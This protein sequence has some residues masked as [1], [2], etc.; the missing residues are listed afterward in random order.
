MD[1]DLLEAYLRV[2]RSQNVM[3]AQLDLPCGKVS[4]VMGPEALEAAPTL[5]APGA[6]KTAGWATPAG[7]E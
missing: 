4:V 3:S 7:D 1:P 6:W 5:D 2:L